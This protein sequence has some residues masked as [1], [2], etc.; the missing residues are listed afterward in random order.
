MRNPK[1]LVARREA[2]FRGTQT[3]HMVRLPAGFAGAESYTASQREA[4]I[5]VEMAES[6]QKF[7]LLARCPSRTERI[8]TDH[9]L[10]EP[11]AAA[12]SIRT[13]QKTMGV[14]LHLDLLLKHI[15]F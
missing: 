15:W 5:Q 1:V 2:R 10:L 9:T 3:V 13:A 7:F 8:N 14:A 4:G 6:Q 11:E 12:H